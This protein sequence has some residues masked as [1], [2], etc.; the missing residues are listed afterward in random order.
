MKRCSSSTNHQGN[1]NQNYKLLLLPHI[2]QNRHYQK[3]TIVGKQV[4]KLGGGKGNP[5]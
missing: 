2:L 5:L 1:A 4:K 3:I